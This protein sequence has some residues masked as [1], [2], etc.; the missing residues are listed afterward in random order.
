MGKILLDI[1]T[2]GTVTTSLFLP[3]VGVV[4]YYTLAIWYP[5]AIWRWIFLDSR[6]AQIVALGTLVGFAGAFL[7]G[8]ISYLNLRNKQNFFMLFLWLSLISSYLLNPY[9]NELFV[10]EE[11]FYFDPVK[12]MT[13]LMKI[14][15]F[16]FISVFLID[17]LK[18][19]K[20][21]VAVFVVTSVYY[22]YWANY[23]FLSGQMYSMG[24]RLS[25]PGLA[26]IYRDEN[27]FAMLFVIG[28]PFLFFI[29]NYFKN[30]LLKFFLWGCIPLAWHAVFLTGSLG[31]LI[32]LIVS[33]FFIAIR[34]KN[35]G[36]LI[37]IPVALIIAFMSQG[38]DYLKKKAAGAGG[39]VTKQETAQT[40]FESWTAGYKMMLD[41]P[42]TGVG[43]ANFVKAYPDYSRTRPYVAHNTFFQLAGEAGF[44]AGLMY[45]LLCANVFFS[46]LKI[47]KLE[48][49]G[50][51][52]FY[53]AVKNASLCGIVGYFICS[54]FLN[55]AAYELFHFLL[56]LNVVQHSQVRLLLKKI[57]A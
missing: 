57:E 22:V 37:A 16:Y 11:V 19:L 50:I 24:Y 32:G 46:N 3:W 7:G 13:I 47:G 33:T 42:L 29:G 23:I 56:I 31:G 51:D 38:G 12:E 27:T 28:V 15:L 49:E 44:F 18:K 25:G 36:L 34:S 4:A 6:I 45:L 40:R 39:D 17:D 5:Q 20:C 9:G 21:L 10:H 55:L 54:M 30:K 8:K 26:G 2:F 52:K 43:V 35:K 48:D 41:H 14:Y 1:L 53:L